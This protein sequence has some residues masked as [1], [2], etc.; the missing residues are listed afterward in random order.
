M[1]AEVERQVPVRLCCGQRHDGAICPDGLVQ[2]CICFSRFP[3]PELHVDREG[4]RWDVCKTCG[5]AEEAYKR[6]RGQ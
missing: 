3:V 1:A 4:D 2:C 5:A 6:E